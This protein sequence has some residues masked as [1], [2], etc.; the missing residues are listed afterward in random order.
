MITNFMVELSGTLTPD[1]TVYIPERYY[2]WN[3]IS[4]R[5]VSEHFDGVLRVNGG[6][7]IKCHIG[8]TRN[9]KPFVWIHSTSPRD[10][11][12][13]TCNVEVE[14]TRN[15][16]LLGWIEHGARSLARYLLKNAKKLSAPKEQSQ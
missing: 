9:D 14:V 4:L 10:Q 7:D 13:I 5:L 3:R 2:L 11:I 1:I 8:K 6:S 16:S 12:N 15:Y